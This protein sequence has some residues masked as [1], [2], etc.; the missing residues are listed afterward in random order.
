MTLSLPSEE[1]MAD[2]RAIGFIMDDE[3]QVDR[4]R[5]IDKRNRRGQAGLARLDK[6][7]DWL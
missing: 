7:S 4:P 6:S 1:I 5:E 3:A 2:W